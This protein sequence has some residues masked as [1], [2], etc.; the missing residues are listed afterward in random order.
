MPCSYWVK[1]ICNNCNKNSH[2]NSSSAT[3]KKHS[4]TTRFPEQEFSSGS[5][6]RRYWLL[7]TT[8]QLR[9]VRGSYIR[10]NGKHY[11]GMEQPQTL[12]T[13]EIIQRLQISKGFISMM[14]F[15]E[16]VRFQKK[17]PDKMTPVECMYY[18]VA[19]YGAELLTLWVAVI[20]VTQSRSTWDLNCF[21]MIFSGILM[22]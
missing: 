19:I 8:L 4:K 3:W 11:F 16:S 13:S 2:L 7:L 15:P 18:V 9:L 22:M 17:S 6:N 12:N 5:A 20:K 1:G 10:L 21:T 14:Y